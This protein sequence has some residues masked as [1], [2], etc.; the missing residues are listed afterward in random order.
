MIFIY[1]I[2]KLLLIYFSLHAIY[3][4]FFSIA[5]F[6]Y[7][8][9]KTY[10]NS[11]NSIR[12]IAVL[13]PSYKED[14]VILDTVTKNLKQDFPFNRFKI[15]VIADSLQNRT[16]EKL[17]ELPIEIINV[18]F[19]NS[20]KVKSLNKALAVIGDEYEVSVILDAD[21][22][23][24][25]DFIGKIDKVFSRSR[26]IVVQGHRTAKNQNTPFAVLDAISEGI[27]NH[28]FRKGFNAV[29]LS[30][31]IIGSGMAF[32]TQLLR[33]LLKDSNA[34]GGFDRELQLKVV[35]S[36]YKILYLDDAIVF[37]EKVQ[38]VTVYRNQRTRWIS[39]QYYYLFKFFVPG[40]RHLLRGR[41]QYFKFSIL[42]NFFLPQILAVGILLISSFT[43][44]IIHLHQNETFLQLW[45]IIIFM[46]FLSIIISIPNKF[47]QQRLLLSA[48]LQI[49]IAYFIMFRSLFK[50]RQSNKRFIHT[51]HT[52]FDL[53][54]EK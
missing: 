21:N 52:N 11:L 49:P 4:S 54:N 40:F 7:K 32:E 24:S 50:V 17:N 5:G 47:I 27:N 19:K 45:L 28:I 3:L 10:K 46:I 6:F 1:F 43:F 25:K 30:S 2:E 44:S 15:F 14:Q 29:G 12:R 39:S 34:I 8:K 33:K 35:E 22:V 9:R 53:T 26:K 31:A 13:I 20:T 42:T 38:K 37:D 36:G 48:I 18:S 16:L 41:F 51:P 23:M